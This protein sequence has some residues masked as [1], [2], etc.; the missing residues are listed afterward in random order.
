MLAGFLSHRKELGLPMTVTAP[1]TGRT[2]DQQAQLSR[3]ALTHLKQL[4]AEAIHIIR[5]VAAEFSNPV[6]LYSIG[7]DSSVMVRLAQKAFYPGRIPFPLLSALLLAGCASVPQLGEAPKPAPAESKPAPTPAPGQ[8]P[9]APGKTDAP[10]ATPASPSSQRW[11]VQVG[12]FADIDNARKVLASLKSAGQPNLLA[13]VET[14]KGT[15]YRVRGGPYA[16]E[17]AAQQALGTIKALGYP[18]S[19]IVNP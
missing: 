8:K 15:I 14:G 4:E 13:P 5:E 2:A 10:H 19:Q 12:G 16:S 18:G 17:A 3:P 1:G 7:K 6:M 11:Y 9:A